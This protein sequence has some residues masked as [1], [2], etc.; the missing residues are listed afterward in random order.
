MSKP[1]DTKSLKDKLAELQTLIAWFDSDDFSLEAALDKYKAA[2]K[3][4]ADIDKELAEFKNAIE[5][6]KQNFDAA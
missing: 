1:N 4:A 5:V 2:E 6:V 3:L